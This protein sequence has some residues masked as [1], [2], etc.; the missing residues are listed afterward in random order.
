M[1]CDDSK[2][3]AQ[4]LSKAKDL[5]LLAHEYVYQREVLDT[6]KYKLLFEVIYKL[7]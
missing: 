7:T 4:K 1:K 6:T 2:G 5:V 3:Y